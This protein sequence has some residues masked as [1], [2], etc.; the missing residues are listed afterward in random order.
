MAGSD[1]GFARGAFI[2][3]NLKSILFTFTRLGKRD[4]VTVVTGEVGFA[5]VFVSEVGNRGVELLLIG[6]EVVD[7]GALW[8]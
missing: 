1:A 3:G 8:W 2:E 5:V 7:E 4:Q 6:E